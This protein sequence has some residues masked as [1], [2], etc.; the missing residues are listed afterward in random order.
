MND[1]EDPTHSHGKRVSAP[2]SPEQVQALD[3]FQHGYWHPF[4]CSY[5]ARP[6]HG[7]RPLV[8]TR[9][10]WHCPDED[11]EYTQDWAHDFMADLDWVRTE[12]TRMHQV[13][14]RRWAPDA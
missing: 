4:T 2:F 1:T 10:G 7:D 14:S 8:A 3:L 12:M 9:E 6:G 11:C 5:R 13:F